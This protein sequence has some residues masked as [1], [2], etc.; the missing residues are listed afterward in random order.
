[1][2]ALM[3]GHFASSAMRNFSCSGVVHLGAGI[4]GGVGIAG[5]KNWV[6]WQ[7]VGD[8]RSSKFNSAHLFVIYLSD[9][10][11]LAVHLGAFPCQRPFP[12][13]TWSK[14]PPPLTPKA[15][16]MSR[17]SRRSM[18]ISMSLRVKRCLGAVPVL[19]TAERMVIIAVSHSSISPFSATNLLPVARAALLAYTR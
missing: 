7:N 12:S 3:T 14:V 13:P 1:M 19:C 8:V 9:F 4:R 6:S 16:A 2:P 15:P 17:M 5:N 10:Y 18:Y 11:I